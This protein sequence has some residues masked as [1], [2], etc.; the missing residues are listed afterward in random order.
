[1]IAIS[2][3]KVAVKNRAAR[4][5]GERGTIAATSTA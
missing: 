2:V 5:G 3:Q 1:V 4:S